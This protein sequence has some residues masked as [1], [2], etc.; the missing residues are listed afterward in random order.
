M[1][2]TLLAGL[3]D[4]NRAFLV[5]LAG[6]ILVY[7][8]C[9]RP[10]RILPGVAGAVFV[11]IAIYA[12]FQHPW[13][14]TGAILLL[15][16]MGFV[17]LQS[18]RVWFWLPAIA[19]AAC[20]TCGAMQLVI[21]PSIRPLFAAAAIPFTALSVWLLRAAVRARKNKRSTA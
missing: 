21:V 20:L 1:R 6:M 15:A 19:A 16:G 5:L 7:R 2:H 9:V 8:E 3:S 13:S 14:W 17:V 10:G 12:L 18:V 11:V 4:P